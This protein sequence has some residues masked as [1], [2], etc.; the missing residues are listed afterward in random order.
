[1]A[2]DQAVLS[3]WTD[4]IHGLH[5]ELRTAEVETGEIEHPLSMRPGKFRVIDPDG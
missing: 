1:M 3:C 5:D 2:S 4:D